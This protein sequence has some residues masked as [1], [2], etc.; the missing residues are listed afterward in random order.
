MTLKPIDHITQPCGR[1]CQSACLAM[2]TGQPVEKLIERHHADLETGNR[3][4]HEVCERY[5]VVVET[6]DDLENIFAG[7]IYVLIVSS[8]L[9]TELHMIIVDARDAENIR[10][11][12]PASNWRQSINPQENEVKLRAFVV[13]YRVVLAPH[14]GVL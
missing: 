2:L 7:S 11:Y 6:P 10:V 8:G 14:L 13:R 4:F 3:R 12:D 9:L 1:S 5:G